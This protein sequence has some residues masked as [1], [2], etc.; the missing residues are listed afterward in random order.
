VAIKYISG[1]DIIDEN[2]D[3]VIE[4]G[5]VLKGQPEARTAAFY[6][7]AYSTFGIE[8]AKRVEGGNEISIP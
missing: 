8:V 6:L 2:V 4:E 1:P 5:Q 3:Q 7:R